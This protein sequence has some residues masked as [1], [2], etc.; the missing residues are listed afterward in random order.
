MTNV[1]WWIWLIGGALAGLL[2]LHVPGTYLIWVAVGAG[3]TALIDATLQPAIAVQ[4]AIFIIAC[5]VSCTI[6][7]F[8][9]RRASRSGQAEPL[10]NQRSKAMIGQKGVVSASI[11]NGQGKVRLGDTVWLAEGPN[12]PEGT[13]IVVTAVRGTAVIVAQ[14]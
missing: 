10:L 8:V 7:Y 14:A 2:E 3:V 9:Y 5:A 11:M 12:L 1:P 13:A 4:I 6:G